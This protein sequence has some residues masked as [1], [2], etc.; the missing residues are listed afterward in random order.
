MSTPSKLFEPTAPGPLSLPNRIAMAPMTRSRALDNIPN[1]LMRDYYGQRASAGLVITEG[2]S[3]SPDGLGYARIPGLFNEA[4]A[5]GWQSIADAVHAGGARLV[6]QLMHTGRIG[7][8][9]NLPGG[10]GEL[11][12]PSAI[13]A[14][15]QMWT[16]T[17]GM[18]PHPVPRAMDAEDLARVRDDFVRAAQLAIASGLDGV[19]LHAA[20]GYLL[21]Q[22]LNPGSN[23]RDDA[24]GGTAQNRRRF[25]LEVVDAVSAAIGAGRVGIRISPFNP[26]NDLAAN[27]AGELDETLDLVREL[28]VRRLG[29]LHLIATPGSVP[30]AVVDSV[31]AAFPGTLILAGDYSR[32]RAEA[33]LASGRADV[34]AFGRPFIANPDL[35]ARLLHR[36]ELA[37][38][39]AEKL[40][41]P[42]AD[43]YSDYP[44][45]VRETAAA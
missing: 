20:N 14:A 36:S 12:A 34:I 1:A 7:H 41:T 37:K 19:E 24:Y 22:F 2:T 10:A 42:G 11:I 38:F 13:A 4:Q 30:S 27:Y 6:V 33:E 31:R 15:G 43:G 18:Q 39:A 16:D 45:L 17:A 40:Y 28:A 32:D 35:P 23:L 3:P 25:V 29:Y 5:Q 44:A 9:L 26:F 21:A 8:P